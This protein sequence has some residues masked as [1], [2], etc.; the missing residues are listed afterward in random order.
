MPVTVCTFLASKHS[1]KIQLTEM[2]KACLYMTGISD[3]IWWTLLLGKQFFCN[4]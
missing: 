3:Y 2:S 1:T 4:I